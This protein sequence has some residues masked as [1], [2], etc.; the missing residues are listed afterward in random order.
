MN[1]HLTYPPTELVTSR[2]LELFDEANQLYSNGGFITKDDI[3][4][5]YD[6]AIDTFLKSLDGSIV[7]SLTN[8]KEG[9]PADPVAFNEFTSAVEKD[10]KALFL[11]VGALDRSVSASFNSIVALREQVLND[12]RRVGNKIGNYLLYADPALGAGFFFGDSFSS[13]DRVDVQSNL[14]EE[15][16]CF[17]SSSEGAI[18]LPLDGEPDRAQ[19]E[20]YTINAPSNGTLGNNSEVGVFGH[21]SLSVIGDN[22][23]DTWVEYEKVTINDLTE[24][25]VF[26]L[27]ITLTSPVIVNHIHIY[28]INFGTPTPVH[29]ET[30]ETSKDGIEY[31]SIKDEIPLGDFIS[32]EEEDVFSLSSASSKFSGQGFYSFLPRRTKY[33]HLVFLQYTPYNIETNFGDRLRYAVG[34]RDINIYS[35]KFKAKGSLVSKQFAVPGDARKVALWASENPVEASVLADI[36]HEISHDNGGSWLKIQ[37]Q[38]RSGTEIPEIVNFNNI[39]DG[40]VST[41]SSVS[42][43]RHKVSME[44]FPEAFEGG[45]TLKQ[46]KVSKVEIID[47]PAGGNDSIELA[48]EP[49]SDTVNIVLP[50]WGS[51]S[52]PRGRQGTSIVNQSTPM[53]LDFVEFIVDN[54]S[55]TGTIRYSL[56]YEGYEDVAQRLRV[57]ING[58]QWQ[59]CAID[60]T[61]F[62]NGGGTSY[63]SGIDS[64]SRVY[65]LRKNG[66]ELIFGYDDDGTPRG[67]IPAAGAKVQ[68]CLDGDNPQLQLTEDGYLLNLLASS[69]GIKKNVRLVAFTDI[70]ETL[71]TPYQVNLPPGKIRDNIIYPPEV[72]QYGMYGKPTNIKNIHQLSVLKDRGEEFPPVFLEGTANF[73]IKEYNLDG[74]L[75]TGGDRYYQTPVAFVDGEVELTSAEMYTFDH[76]TGKVYLSTAP[77]AT[78]R[79][80]FTCYTLSSAIVEEEEWDFYRDPAN[81]KVD[82]S[83]IN[84]QPSAVHTISRDKSVS[85]DDNHVSLLTENTDYHDWFNQRIVKGSVKFDPHIMGGDVEPAEVPF[86]DGSSELTSFVSTKETVASSAASVADIYSFSL[87]RIGSTRT[88][89]GAPV[90]T[91]LRTA[92]QITAPSSQF[93]TQLKEG[94]TLTSNGEWKVVDG[95]VYLYLTTTLN[96]HIV[97]YTYN[98]LGTGLDTAGLFSVDYENGVI[99]FSQAL[100]RDGTISYEV[101]AYSAFYNIAEV[102][103]KGNIKEID[104]ESKTIVFETDFTSAF[105]KQGTAQNARPQF[106][107]I[108]YDYYEKTTESLKD[109][110]P[111]F[112]PICKDIALRAVLAN[113]GSI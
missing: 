59:Y 110:E 69:D 20:S 79:T 13:T 42:A 39:S 85:T 111:F 105:L 41:D 22:N 52:C 113:L 16:E 48:E 71:K 74:D 18:L 81:G 90:F 61:A 49:I 44:R 96:S 108:F 92:G 12:L 4:A 84:L 54:P 98:D 14:I 26:D 27:T 107:K 76:N 101:T 58:E 89:E 106:M 33:I 37:P 87:S 55:D 17:I 50:F 36:G 28:P 100:S 38:D 24:P 35:R 9:L 32:E 19:I 11:E 97:S 56:P 1:R 77:S 64:D 8:I 82:T 5:A 95:T 112:S 21:D 6:F 57:F 86:V 91:P 75:I 34:I 83:K 47:V 103:D 63:T 25:L 68:V 67:K 73:E 93:T 80:M 23:P 94:D 45:I 72:T 3:I 60:S 43:L 29:I 104:E 7:E 40:S 51:F 99:H 109:I 65:F 102:V 10:V 66:L 53:N 30:I 2:L 46:E 15:E 88:L 78:R 70:D 62:S 31:V